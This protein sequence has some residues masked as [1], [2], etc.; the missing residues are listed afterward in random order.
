MKLTWT[1]TQDN[2]RVEIRIYQAGDVIFELLNVLPADALLLSKQLDMAVSKTIVWRLQN[3]QKE[4][5]L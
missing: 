3:I 5:G 4:S 1:V 2:D